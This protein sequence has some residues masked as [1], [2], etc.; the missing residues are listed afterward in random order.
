MDRSVLFV[1]ILGFAETSKGL[2]GQPPCWDD[3][4]DLGL[5]DFLLL[6]EL[7]GLVGGRRSGEKASAR[8][9]Y[10]ATLCGEKRPLLPIEGNSSRTV[11]LSRSRLPPPCKRL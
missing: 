10:T 11:C 2:Q 8:E 7:R 4:C 3:L 9:G 5:R 1:G 6:S